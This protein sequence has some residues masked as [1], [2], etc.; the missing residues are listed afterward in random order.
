MLGSPA[1]PDSARGGVKDGVVPLE[2]AKA[3]AI[4]GELT[5]EAGVLA[6]DAGTDSA[7]APRSAAPASGKRKE[8]RRIGVSASGTQ[9]GQ[10]TVTGPASTPADRFLLLSERWLVAQLPWPCRA[11]AVNRDTARRYFLP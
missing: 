3:A 10:Q 4:T 7:G 11:S 6:A 1:G 8:K 5:A 9:D 2:D